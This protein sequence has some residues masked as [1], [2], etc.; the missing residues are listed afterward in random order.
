MPE[1]R[2]YGIQEFLEDINPMDQK[3]IQNKYNHIIEWVELKKSKYQI[4]LYILQS[5]NYPRQ[6]LFSC[7]FN[8]ILAWSHHFKIQ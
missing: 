5:S 3:M 6:I 4:F 2:Q 1:L 8:N 7:Y